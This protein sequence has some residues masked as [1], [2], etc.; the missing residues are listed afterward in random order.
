MISKDLG[1]LGGQNKFFLALDKSSMLCWAPARPR[2]LK[3]H[4]QQDSY[5]IT[6]LSLWWSCLD[7]REAPVV[8]LVDL[9][10]EDRDENEIEGR[11]RRGNPNICSF[12]P[13][14]GSFHVLTQQETLHQVQTLSL[15][16]SREGKRE[17]NCPVSR[18]D[19]PSIPG[20]QDAVSPLPGLFSLTLM[21]FSRAKQEHPTNQG[22]GA[23]MCVGGERDLFYVVPNLQRCS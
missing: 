18:A 15:G 4:C 5:I 23:C 22:S 21:S 8:R 1:F 20:S 12:L 7:E 14:D 11:K 6:F 19:G 9:E 17:A 10:D 3:V 16:L 13:S 2:T